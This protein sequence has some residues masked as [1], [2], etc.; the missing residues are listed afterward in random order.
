[1]FV[2]FIFQ[3]VVNWCSSNNL[4]YVTLKEWCDLT[5]V[6]DYTAYVQSLGTLMR[7]HDDKLVR[8]FNLSLFNHNHS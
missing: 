1:M 4:N 6:R 8:W 5:G 2:F 3:K 7:F